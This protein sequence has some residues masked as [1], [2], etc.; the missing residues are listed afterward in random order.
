MALFG[1]QDWLNS[2]ANALN[3][4]E[5]YAEAAQEWEGDFYFLVTPGGNY[6]NDMTMYLHLEH[7]KC[8]VAEMVADPS[9]RKPDY[10]V[11]GALESWQQIITKELDHT[12]AIMTGKLTIKGDMVKI[13]KNL[14]AAQELVNSLV[15]VESE[16]A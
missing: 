6:L 11:K 5:S 13:M 14:K 2:F 1:T 7:G 3:N 12:Q 16:F 10:T 4:N 15:L 9:S 8:L